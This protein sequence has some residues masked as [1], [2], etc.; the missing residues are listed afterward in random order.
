MSAPMRGHV[1]EG[2]SP[3][4]ISVRPKLRASASLGRGRGRGRIAEQGQVVNCPK[5]LGHTR[6][7]PRGPNV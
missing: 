6:M 5:T 4:P 7:P 1:E 3:P 2:D